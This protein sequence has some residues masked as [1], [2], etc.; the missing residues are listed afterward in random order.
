MKK[1]ILFS[2]SFLILVIPAEGQILDRI[3]KRVENKVK[4][5]VDRKI[6]KAVDKGLDHL[7]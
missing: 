6:D 1:L 5:R 4:Q 2:I 3:S 7:R